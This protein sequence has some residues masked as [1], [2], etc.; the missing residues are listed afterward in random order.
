MNDSVDIAKAKKNRNIGIVVAIFAAFGAAARYTGFY[1][2]GAGTIDWFTI[3]IT[4]VA[5]AYTISNHLK[6]GK[7]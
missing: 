1:G 3:V 6:I 2:A 7:Q 4:V 5:L